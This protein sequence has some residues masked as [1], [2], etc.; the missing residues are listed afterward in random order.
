MAVQLAIQI[1]RPQPLLLLRREH[2]VDLKNVSEVAVQAGLSTLSSLPSFSSTNPLTGAPSLSSAADL[3]LRE[4]R[5]LE[6]RQT[7]DLA[8]V[9]ELDGYL[10]NV[11]TPKVPPAT[12]AALTPEQQQ[13]YVKYN[14]IEERAAQI[15]LE[16]AELRRIPESQRRPEQ[17][18][19]IG[20]LQASQTEV[21]K[22][23]KQF[24][25]SPNVAG[26]AKAVSEAA[27]KK[28]QSELRNLD[29][30]A[31]L[32]YPLIQDDRL[33]LILVTSDA[34]PIRRTARVSRA[35]LDREIKRFRNALETVYDPSLDAK[36]SGQKLYS[37]LIKPIEDELD[38][39]GAKTILYAP[40]AQLRY[41]PL[42]AL[43]D[44]KK[45]LVQKYRIN[46]ITAASLHDFSLQP[47]AH[48]QSILAGA[49]TR[50][51]NFKIGDRP[52]VLLACPSPDAKWKRLLRLFLI[53][54]SYSMLI[55]AQN[56]HA[57]S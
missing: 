30:N 47:Q 54:P 53:A 37:W 17:L 51:M 16:L 21:G 5:I 15:D 22:E 35:E 4:G 27:L 55:S 20:K 34:E 49:V 43:Y 18:E 11:T 46:N 23:F 32:L 48:Q 6:A 13:L 10:G 14:Q 8:I 31:V 28:L 3:L 1:A 40:Y 50:G 7:L 42:A 36:D 26:L 44:G 45:W 56:Q 2:S 25:N 12:I 24:I 41:I 39:V 52:S 9:K 57:D 19:R 33:E 29:R 38:R